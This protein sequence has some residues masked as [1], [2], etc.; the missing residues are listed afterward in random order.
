MRILNIYRGCNNNRIQF[1]SCNISDI[2]K[3]CM[4]IG[5]YS[6]LLIFS[7]VT[8]KSNVLLKYYSTFLNR[9]SVIS[10]IKVQYAL[11]IRK[12]QKYLTNSKNLFCYKIWFPLLYS[13]ISFHR[14]SY[15][16]LSKELVSS[17]STRSRWIT[18]S[19]SFPP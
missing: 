7:F 13:K 14:V 17:G 16:I 15:P 2:L 3:L 18:S 10:A 19:L 12:T 1:R 9:N 6:N 5:I 8:G 4:Y 11:S